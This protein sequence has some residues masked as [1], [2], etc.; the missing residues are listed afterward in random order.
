MTD[1]AADPI[2]GDLDEDELMEFFKNHTAQGPGH[3]IMVTSFGACE[4]CGGICNDHGNAVVSIFST[5]E[6]AHEFMDSLPE[7]FTSDVEPMIVDNPG[8]V[9]AS[10]MH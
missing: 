3:L 2:D 1:L 8:F 4:E 5:W 9:D 7:Y 10:E 6:K